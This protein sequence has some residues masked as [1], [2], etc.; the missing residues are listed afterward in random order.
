MT[1][2]KGGYRQGS[3]RPR[4]HLILDNETAR[5][6]SS[7][8]KSWRLAQENPELQ[9]EEVVAQLLTEMMLTELGPLLLRLTMFT[10]FSENQKL[11]DEALQQEYAALQ[12]QVE[13]ALG[14]AGLTFQWDRA[15][16]RYQLTLE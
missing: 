9:E 16:H 14:R 7:R 2:Q 3:G 1:K 4:R 15:S 5:K 12:Q 10:Q 11:S 13:Q 8:T 6:L